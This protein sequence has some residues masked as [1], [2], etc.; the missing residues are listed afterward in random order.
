MSDQPP[1]F[2]PPPWSAPRPPMSRR[3]KVLLALVGLLTVSIV[4][5]LFAL[6]AVYDSILQ[7]VNSEGGTE[8]AGAQL[9]RC[10]DGDFSGVAADEVPT[11]YAGYDLQATATPVDFPASAFAWSRI[12]PHCGMKAVRDDGSV[13][14]YAFVADG[15]SRAEFE[16][17]STMLV[18]LGLVMN[19]DMSSREQQVLPPDQVSSIDPTEYGYLYRNFVIRDGGQAWIAFFADDLVSSSGTGQLV[20]GYTP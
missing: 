19:T 10:E 2:S 1:P 11:W 13:Y 3:R 20:F 16:G 12:D 17:A 6:N 5:A 8:E 15:V 7:R 14:D 18:A 9:T 4:V